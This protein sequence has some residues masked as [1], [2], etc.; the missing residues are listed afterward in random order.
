MWHIYKAKNLSH[1]HPPLVDKIFQDKKR[2]VLNLRENRMLNVLLWKSTCTESYS[3]PE[4]KKEM[5][6]KFPEHGGFNILR[7]DSKRKRISHQ[8]QLKIIQNSKFS[9]EEY[10]ASLMVAYSNKY[11][12]LTFSS[13]DKTNHTEQQINIASDLTPISKLTLRFDDISSGNFKWD[14][15]PN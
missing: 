13:D 7:I 3:T 11:P 5:D 4:I 1:N 6:G 12:T 15:L 10:V 2:N 9:K 8:A 14:C